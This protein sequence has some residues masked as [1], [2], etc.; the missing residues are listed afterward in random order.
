MFPRGMIAL[1]ISMAQWMIETP[2][3]FEETI[4]V[5]I[6]EKLWIDWCRVIVLPPICASPSAG[7]AH[8]QI[9]G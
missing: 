7:L 5:C 1:E 9:A 4:R 8:V 3:I 2:T 6:F